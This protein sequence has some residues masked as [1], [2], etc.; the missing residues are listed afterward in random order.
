MFF[1][2]WRM[3]RQQRKIAEMAQCQARMERQ[4]TL[5][6]A[7]KAKLAASAAVASP[8]ER[9]RFFGQLKSLSALE[10]YLLRAR[11]LMAQ[12]QTMTEASQLLTDVAG[13]LKM[14]GVGAGDLLPGR[15]GGQVD[16]LAHLA[17]GNAEMNE[18]LESGARMLEPAGEDRFSSMEAK[19]ANR[20]IDEARSQDEKVER[21]LDLCDLSPRPKVA[22]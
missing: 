15:L 5:T 21:I 9:E 18:I 14:A 10:A 7:R 4:I 8:Q 19:A 2:S 22:P 12:R 11:D 6:R 13:T 3:R 20:H 17:D 1:E 16:E